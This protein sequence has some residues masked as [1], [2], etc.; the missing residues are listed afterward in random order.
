MVT[1]AVALSLVLMGA[2]PAWSA[3]GSGGGRAPGNDGNRA[4]VARLVLTASSATTAPADPV[5][6]VA[7]GYD[8]AGRD[9]GD[10]TAATALS[11]DPDGSCSGARCSASRPGRHSVTATLRHGAHAVSDSTVLTVLAP[12][13][14]RATPKPTTTPRPGTTPTPPPRASTPTPRPTAPGKAPTTPPPAEHSPGPHDPSTSRTP[15]PPPST[16]TQPLTPTDPTRVT[17]PGERPLEGSRLVLSPARTLAHP[18][19]PVTYTARIRAAD[20]TDLGDVTART[21]VEIAFSGAGSAGPP[22]HDGSCSA[23]TCTGTHFGRHTLTGTA[24]LDG[25]TLTGSAALQVVP[26]LRWAVP[27]H[28]LATV[29]LSPATSV[30]EAGVARV[31][32]ATGYDSNHRLLGDV[33]ALTTFSIGPDGSCVRRPAP[34]R[35]P[36]PTP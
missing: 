30:V 36:G 7:R 26:R 14:P 35:R 33:T 5:T 9:L 34:P 8:R 29:R 31:Y 6:F 16:E 32:T 28:R 15:T 22:H 24:Q 20:G 17:T 19:E 11:I 27:L 3:G 23:T 21:S 12:P 1:A 2:A 4:A 13:E 10:V 25:V 18:G